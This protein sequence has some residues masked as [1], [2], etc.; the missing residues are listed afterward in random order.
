M[1][2]LVTRPR[3]PPQHTPSPALARRRALGGAV[4][5][6]RP[7][8]AGGAGRVWRGGVAVA[9]SSSHDSAEGP[10]EGLPSGATALLALGL[11][12]GANWPKW[13]RAYYRTGEGRGAGPDPMATSWQPGAPTDGGGEGA[14]LLLSVWPARGLAWACAPHACACHSAGVCSRQA[15]ARYGALM[16]RTKSTPS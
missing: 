11:G 4:R 13:G 8:A 12:K 15:C 14:R 16:R 10:M 5:P 6:V 7:G 2:A 3:P 9:S 1:A